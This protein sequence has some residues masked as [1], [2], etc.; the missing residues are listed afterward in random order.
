[1]NKKYKIMALFGKAGAG[2]DTIQNI[3]V[4]DFPTIPLN[5]VGKSFTIIF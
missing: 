2:K 5:I 1:M 3:I 4:N